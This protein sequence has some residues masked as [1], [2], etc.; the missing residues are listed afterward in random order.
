MPSKSEFDTSKTKTMTKTKTKTKTKTNGPPNVFL[1][2]GLL[3]T[4]SSPNQISAA[5]FNT[6]KTKTKTKTRTDDMLFI[7]WSELD[8][9]GKRNVR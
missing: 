5:E 2:S 9:S 3:L 7:I 4:L 6:S 1:A 8:T